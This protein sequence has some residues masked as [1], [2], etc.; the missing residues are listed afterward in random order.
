MAEV[1]GQGEVAFALVT[2]DLRK[3]HP[4]L[5]RIFTDRWV[6][7]YQIGFGPPLI[8]ANQRLIQR[9]K[10]SKSALEKLEAYVDCCL[11]DAD[12]RVRLAGT[13]RRLVVR[14]QGAVEA[15]VLDEKSA[16]VLD[17][18]VRIHRPLDAPEPVAL[19]MEREGIARSA[20]PARVPPEA[21]TGRFRIKLAD[22][23]NERLLHVAAVRAAAQA[24]DRALAI[25]LRVPVGARALF[26]G[27]LGR[28]ER[29]GAFRVV[30]VG[31]PVSHAKIGKDGSRS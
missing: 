6:A 21:L 5:V 1:G 26:A 27:F 12:E 13:F 15:E 4:T 20:Y 25:E 7:S 22:P 18:S 23:R 10:A 14:A 3:L 2:D 29:A 30:E 31:D 16:E 8:R 28:H 9:V 19:E 24:L 11:L 17:L